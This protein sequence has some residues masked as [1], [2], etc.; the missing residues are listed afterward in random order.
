MSWICASWSWKIGI[1]VC[2]KVVCLSMWFMLVRLCSRV[3][4]SFASDSMDG[5]HTNDEISVWKGQQ[6]NYFPLSYFI[7]IRLPWWDWLPFSTFLLTSIAP[8]VLFNFFQDFFRW[9]KK[10]D[11]PSS[12]F[13]PS[14]PVVVSYWQANECFFRTY[15]RIY[16]ENRGSL[17]WCE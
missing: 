3:K 16:C 4:F 10:L 11:T 15:N 5:T 14:T 8:S 2:S 13:F 6:E 9:S 1:F 12:I 7:S 17:G